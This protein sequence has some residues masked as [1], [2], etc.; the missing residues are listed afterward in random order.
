MKKPRNQK[1]LILKLAGVAIGVAVLLSGGLWV[2]ATTMSYKEIADKASVNN[3]RDLLLKD[4]PQ[5]APIDAKTGN[6]Y[7]REAGLYL[8]APDPSIQLVYSYLP[9]AGVGDVFSVT[10][11]HVLN[12]A[13]KGFYNA[14]TIDELFQYVPKWQACMQGITLSYQK[15]DIGDD[16]YLDGNSTVQSTIRLSNGKDLYVYLDKACPDLQST[17]TALQKLQV[18]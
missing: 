2:A 12:R 17:V 6:V 3:Y 7:L 1:K 15:Q 18:Y 5:D 16:S 11:R 10:N 9:E 13:E 8:P 14:R 4:G